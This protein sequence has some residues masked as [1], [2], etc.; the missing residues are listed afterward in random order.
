[1]QYLIVSFTFH[2]WEGGDFHLAYATDF[3]GKN[4]HDMVGVHKAQSR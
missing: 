4:N 1:M 3:V 2:S